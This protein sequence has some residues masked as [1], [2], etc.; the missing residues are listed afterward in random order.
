[1]KHRTTLKGARNLGSGKSGT[2][3]WWMQRFSAIALV[4]L[5]LWFVLGVSF[6]GQ[7]D[8]ATVQAW[9]SQPIHVVLLVFLVVMSFYHAAIGLQVVIEDY[10]H[11]GVMKLLIMVLVNFVA[12]LSVGISLWSIFRVVF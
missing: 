11:N 5:T 1:M 12:L 2:H 8:F 10:V 4:P 9:V 7:S 6:H 3:H